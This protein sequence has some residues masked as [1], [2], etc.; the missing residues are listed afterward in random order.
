MDIGKLEQVALR[1]IWPNEALDFTVWLAE[2][3]DFLGE[4][5]DMDLSL[6]ERE[7]AAGPFSADI[8]AEDASGSSV[9]I[10]NQLERTDHDHLGSW[11]PT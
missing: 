7:A 11:S 6:V 3:L 5:L 2:N 1:E 8:L 10:E 4:T 9:I